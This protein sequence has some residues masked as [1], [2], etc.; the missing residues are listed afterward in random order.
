MR[1][2]RLLVWKASIR[3]NAGFGL[4]EAPVRV[5]R[6]RGRAGMATCGLASPLDREPLDA[7]VALAVA[8]ATR[9]HLI[10]QVLGQAGRHRGA[11]EPLDAR[12]GVDRRRRQRVHGPLR[13]VGPDA[14]EP[15]QHE[16]TLKVERPGHDGEARIVPGLCFDADRRRHQVPSPTEHSNMPPAR[17]RHVTAKPSCRSSTCGPWK[18]TGVLLWGRDEE[19]EAPPSSRSGASAFSGC[20]DHRAPAAGTR[21]VSIQRRISSWSNLTSLGP[22][23]TCGIELRLTIAASVPLLIPVRRSASV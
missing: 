5:P 23:R 6:C 3:R 8:S 16:V 1:C 21:R 22:S 11:G 18:R 17:R 19:D 9:S 12:D 15:D 4:R 7:A 10:A 14:S 2:W 20:T 13:L